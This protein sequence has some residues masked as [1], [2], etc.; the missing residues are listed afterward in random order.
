MSYGDDHGEDAPNR[1][2]RLDGG[3]ESYV[4]KDFSC[5]LVSMAD[6]IDT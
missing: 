4:I 6:G 5:D 2:V 3:A 1:R